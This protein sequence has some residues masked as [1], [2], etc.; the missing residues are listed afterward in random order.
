MLVYTGHEG[1]ETKARD[2]DFYYGGKNIYIICK[3]KEFVW[4]NIFQKQIFLT[5]D[6]HV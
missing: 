3:T 2:F 6:A 4:Y 1:Q 5:A